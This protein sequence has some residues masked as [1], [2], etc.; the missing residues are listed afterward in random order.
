MK[1]EEQIDLEYKR[2]KRH[3]C[4]KCGLPVGCNPRKSPFVWCTGMACDFRIVVGK[5]N[6]AQGWCSIRKGT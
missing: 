6:P 2:I 1:L 4:P 3:Q 5:W